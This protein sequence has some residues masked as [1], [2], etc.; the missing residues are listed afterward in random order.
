M[1]EVDLDGSDVRVVGDFMVAT[2]VSGV[3]VVT[4]L[5]AVVVGKLLL[6]FRVEGTLTEPGIF[7]VVIEVTFNRL[8]SVDVEALL[9]SVSITIVLE[10]VELGASVTVSERSVSGV[11]EEVPKCGGRNVLSL[12]EPEEVTMWVVEGKMENGVMGA[13]V[14]PVLGLMSTHGVWGE[15]GTM[16]MV[17]VSGQGVVEGRE[18]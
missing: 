16:V 1:V 12:V 17:M 5:E 10:S 6:G 14:A 2:E 15:L 8:S 9:K 3:F 7:G 11:M 4:L 13:D 18:I